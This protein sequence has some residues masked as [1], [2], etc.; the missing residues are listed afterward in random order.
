MYYDEGTNKMINR[1]PINLH[2]QAEGNHG[3]SAVG[4]VGEEFADQNHGLGDAPREQSD[5]DGQKLLDLT[6]SLEPADSG[7]Q[8]GVTAVQAQV[9]P[10]REHAVQG[11]ALVV[12][13]CKSL[14]ARSSK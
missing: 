10:L 1:I 3:G 4:L 8:L 9:V 5:A 12:V 13:G 11:K 7:Y 14:I 2:E 6:L